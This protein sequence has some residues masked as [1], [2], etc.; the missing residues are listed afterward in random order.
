MPL[1]TVLFCSQSAAQKRTPWA[2]WSIISITAACSYPANLKEGWKRVLRLEFDDVDRDE[3][4]Y[5]LFSEQQAR[6][7]IEFVATAQKNGT[8]GILVH[9]HAGISRSAAVARWI[10]DTYRLPFPA[11]YCLYNKH[12]YAILRE[13]HILTACE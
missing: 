5:I 6:D 9:C 4:P 10:A 11:S 2:N 1:Q 3:E 13:E 8:E 12:V 7:I